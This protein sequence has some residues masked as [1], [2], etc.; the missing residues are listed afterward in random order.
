MNQ[1]LPQFWQDYPQYS[2]S[3]RLTK[4]AK[5]K[6]F[7]VILTFIL[8]TY[9]LTPVV[10]ILLLLLANVIFTF[11]LLSKI[12]LF[13]MGL[14]VPKSGGYSAPKSLPSFTILVP[15]YKEA[16][17]IPQ[18]LEHLNKLNYPAKKLDIKLVVE[19]DDEITINAINLHKLPKHFS[20]VKTPPSHPRTKPKACNYALQ[21]ADSDITVIFDA[22]DI[23]DPNQLNLAAQ[24]FA[25]LDDSYV[26]LQ[27]R[28]NWYNYGHNALT[29][30]FALDYGSWFAVLLNGFAKL[31]MPIPLGGTSNY[32]KTATLKELGG[33]D[34][35]NVTEDAD[36][37]L[38]LA[39]FGYKTSIINSTTL[40]EAPITLSAWIGQR[41]R[42]IKG[43]MQTYLVH[44]R[45]KVTK[46]G[47]KKFIVLQGFIGATPLILL[48][49][50]IAWAVTLLLQTNDAYLG[51]L[52]LPSWLWWYS[53]ALLIIGIVSQIMMAFYTRKKLGLA[54]VWWQC[55]LYPFY[56]IIHIIAALR[57]F[58]EL[59]FKP[60]YWHK[61]EHGVNVP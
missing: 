25:A 31:G 13:W 43:F 60:F 2:A 37:G 14:K 50:P 12:I 46:G 47:F 45:K 1:F 40:E 19:A 49:T 53:M 48:I 20:V 36:L 11:S 59:I 17:I 41:S 23:P 55:L 22:E 16:K 44:M 34:S 57:A 52:T 35:Y 5:I 56:L 51:G 9:F 42:W 8:A 21:Q 10:I 15:L 38:R 30:F 27:A 26:C 33:W 28:L 7:A 32:I 4:W 6:L 18:T 58:Y 3:R 24:K 29:K 39:S 54:R 61:T